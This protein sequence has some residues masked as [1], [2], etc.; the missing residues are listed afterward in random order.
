[1]IPDRRH[2]DAQVRIVGEQRAAGLPTSP[3]RRPSRSSRSRGPRRGRRPRRVRPSGGGPGRDRRS[4]ARRRPSAG[5]DRTG[6]G[7]CGRRGAAVAPCRRAVGGFARVPAPPD[8]GRPVGRDDR[9]VLAI[10][11]EQLVGPCRVAE[12]RVGQIAEDLRVEVAA[13]VPRLDLAP[14]DRVEVRPWL[15]RDAGGEERQ[16]ERAAMTIEP[17]V[18]ALRVGVEDGPRLRRDGIEVPLGRDAPAEGPDELVRVEL[19][20]P[21]H[22]G[23]PSGR[24]V[25]PD[26]HLPHPLAGMDVALGHEQVVGRVGGDVGDPGRV[27]DHRRRS[28]TSPGIAAVAARLRERASRDPHEETR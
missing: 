16:T 3:G 20:R 9:G 21:E 19:A 24:D 26:L 1:M 17:G 12:L 2:R 7:G 4:S 27:A 15:G 23:Q 6:S 11:R 22:L 8:P 18:D 10:G 5:A 13:E 28:P 25:A 14:R